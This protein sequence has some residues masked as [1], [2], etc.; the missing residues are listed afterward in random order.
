MFIVYVYIN[1]YIYIYIYIC[2]CALCQALIRP[3]S[4]GM[5]SAGASCV[6]WRLLK[7]GVP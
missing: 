1:V 5:D 7:L 3:G 4:S 2:V 6:S